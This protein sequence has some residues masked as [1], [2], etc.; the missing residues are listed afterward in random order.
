MFRAILDASRV[1]MET[2]R[3]LGRARARQRCV[4]VVCSTRSCQRG[5]IWDLITLVWR[6]SSTTPTHPPN[7][8]PPTFI[9]SGSTHIC[10]RSYSQHAMQTIDNTPISA[11]RL[12]QPYIRDS[13]SG[14]GGWWVVGGGGWGELRQY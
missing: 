6:G 7:P 13:L 2:E 5:Y 14:G 4:F 12:I 3:S 8:T 11:S 10:E 9:L 1:A